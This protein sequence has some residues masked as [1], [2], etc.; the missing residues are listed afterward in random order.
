LGAQIAGRDGAAHRINIMAAA[1]AGNLTIEDVVDLD[2]AY[3]PPFTPT[4]DPILTAARVLQKD[5]G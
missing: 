4:I 5:M 1:L 2:L 3:A